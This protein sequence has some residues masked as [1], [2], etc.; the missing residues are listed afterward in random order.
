MSN[1]GWGSAGEV[2]TSNGAGTMPSFQA[3][4]GGPLNSIAL[5]FNADRSN[6]TG[7]GTVFVLNPETTLVS[8]GFSYDPVT[9]FITVT[10]TGTYF[11]SALLEL[12]GINQTHNTCQWIVETSMSVQ[13]GQAEPG[14]LLTGADQNTQF[15]S[16]LDTCLN[17]TAGDTFYIRFTAYGGTLTIGFSNSASFT[18]RITIWQIG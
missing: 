8:N 15:D 10:N 16:R 17:L 7:D 11:I 1:F 13:I 14:N 2:L 12:T 18:N 6:V 5:A 4:G 3:G 9:G